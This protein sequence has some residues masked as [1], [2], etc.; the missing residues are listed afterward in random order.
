MKS[1][2]IRN[3]GKIEDAIEVPDLIEVQLASYG[4][5]IQADAAL[6]KR[7]DE[8]LEALFRE[9]FPPFRKQLMPPLMETRLSFLRALIMKTSTSMGRTLSFA[10]PTPPAPPLSLPR[11]SMVEA[12]ILW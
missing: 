1:R 2:T 11:S 4:R 7:K 9:I 6:D 5:F 10:L 12:L 8:G 3:F